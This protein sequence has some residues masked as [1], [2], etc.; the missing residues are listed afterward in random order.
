VHFPNVETKGGGGGVRKCGNT[1]KREAQG[2][3]LLPVLWHEMKVKSPKFTGRLNTWR[4]PYRVIKVINVFAQS[5]PY[6]M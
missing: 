3:R 2:M 4:I 1:K 6:V 5:S